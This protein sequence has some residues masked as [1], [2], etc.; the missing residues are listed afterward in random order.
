M[1]PAA[2]LVT[3]GAGLPW[4]PAAVRQW[5]T[6]ALIVPALA[7]AAAYLATGAMERLLTAADRAL[8]LPSQR[9]FA[10]LVAVLTTGLALA[11]GW[12]L[13]GLHAVVAD[14]FAQRWQAMLLASGH[15]SAGAESHPE[16]FSTVET[17][18]ING[19]W[20]AQFP[21]GGPLLLATGIAAHAVWLVNP[22]LAGVAAL[23]FYDFLSH[24]TDERVARIAALLFAVCPWML[25]MAGSEMNHVGTLA[26][27][28][29]ALASLAHWSKA[30]TERRRTVAAG[31]IGLSLGVAASIRPF[32]AAVAATCIGIF[33]LREAVERPEFRRSL[34][35]ELAA[36]AI[37]VALLLYANHATVGNA[38]TFAYDALNGPEHRPGFHLTPLGFEHTPRRALYMASAYLMK[39]DVGLFAWP[40]PAM[41]VVAGALWLLRGATRWDVLLVGFAAAL[42]VGY[43]CYW[44]ESYFAGPRFLYVLAPVF[45][46]YTARFPMA[47]MSRLGDTRARLAVALLVPLWLLVSWMA[48]V[49]ESQLYG[50]REVASLY[51]VRAVGPAMMK[52][53]ADAQ[54]H[55]AVVF[56]E[57]G[58]HARLTARLRALGMRPLAAEQFVSHADACTLVRAIGEAELMSDPRPVRQLDAVMRAVATDTDAVPLNL[59]PAEQIA[60]VQQRAPDTVCGRELETMRGNGANLAELMPFERVDDAGTL[61]GDVVF[62]RDLGARNVVLRSRF[63]DRA[64]YGSRVERRGDEID[65]RLLPLGR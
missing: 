65:V 16:F 48:P 35:T 6:W 22:L 59:P 19:R 21:L 62:A 26:F 1:I 54:L 39:L 12:W 25:A 58:L 14:E 20:F 4:W 13:F 11:T 24:T 56:V 33:Q 5:L 27:V 51:K 2:N 63:P 61:D 45:V 52:A 31:A 46:L 60:L 28:W 10:V 32:D 43:A 55:H 34:L 57:E 53:I 38:F 30:G 47:V 29:I 9:T 17:L 49:R 3:T 37:P 8:L 15:L 50:V 64:W 40:V 18:A 7:I 44:S 23:A 41:A 36:M 42:L